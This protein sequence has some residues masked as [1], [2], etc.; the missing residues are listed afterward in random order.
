M[1]GKLIEVLS[2]TVD[3]HNGS[4]VIPMAWKNEPM[5]LLHK[6]Q[7]NNTCQLEITDV[8]PF[9]NYAEPK[10]RF[11]TDHS[12][13]KCRISKRQRNCQELKNEYFYG[14]RDNNENKDPNKLIKLSP[15]E[16]TESCKKRGELIMQSNFIICTGHPIVL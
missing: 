4:E 7:E 13:M 1:V 12:K 6:L 9:N 15:S 8:N 5:E 16:Y 2:T 3:N 11:N 10:G 14:I